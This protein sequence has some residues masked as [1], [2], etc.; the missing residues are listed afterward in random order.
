MIVSFTFRTPITHDKLLP[1]CDEGEHLEPLVVTGESPE[2][3]HDICAID[4]AKVPKDLVTKLYH[5]AELAKE[6][7]GRNACG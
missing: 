1:S 3:E 6:Q 2:M 5:Q 4:N 7:I